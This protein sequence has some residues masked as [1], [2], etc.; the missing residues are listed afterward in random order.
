MAEY[1]EREA[2]LKKAYELQGGSFS[3]GLIVEQIEKAPAVDVVEVKHG[4]WIYCPQ[5]INLQSHFYCSVCNG[6]RLEHYVKNNFKY[7][8]NCGAKMDGGRNE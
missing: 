6:I 5:T 3:T 2:L 7:C 1:I 4:E 8:P